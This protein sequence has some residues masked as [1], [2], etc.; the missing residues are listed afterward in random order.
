ML[1]LR[2]IN[3]ST[4][5]KSQ[6]KSSS[7]DKSDTASL[8]SY[9]T[10]LKNNLK[11]GV[12]QP[13]DPLYHTLESSYKNKGLGRNCIS[14]ENLGVYVTDEMYNNNIPNHCCPP[15]Y[16]YFHYP[17]AYFYQQPQHISIP[18]DYHYNNYLANTAYFNNSATSIGNSK[19]SLDDFRKYRDVAL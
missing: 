18:I 19:Q 3:T 8:N 1:D 13:K 4:T 7:K 11:G 6:S 2:F 15:Q 12:K 14:L 9:D 17:A 5:T 16:P 10:R